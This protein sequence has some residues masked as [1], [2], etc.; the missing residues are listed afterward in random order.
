MNIYE[1]KINSF[2]KKADIKLNGDRP[3]DIQLKDK[4][5]FHKTIWEGTLGFGESYV[6]GYFDCQQLD[7]L[8]YKLS[9]QIE[10]FKYPKYNKHFIMNFLKKMF[11]NFQSIKNARQVVRHHYNIKPE[12]FKNFLD[13]KMLYT[14]G[15]WKKAENLNQSQEH[16]LDLIAK[17]LQ[18]KKGMQVLDVGCGWGG[19]A[20]YF[21]TKYNVQMTAITNS[22]IQYKYAINNNHH[23]NIKFIYQDY[24]QHQGIYDAIYAAGILEHVGS[25][26]Y[27]TFFQKIKNCLKPTA[28]FLLHTIGFPYKDNFSS[29]WITKYIFPNGELPSPTHITKNI[30]HLFLLDDWHNFG[31]DYDKTLM[32][33]Y[34]N[35]IK[36]FENFRDDYYNDKFFRAW[37]FYFLSCAGSFRSRY[38]H[39]WQILL[40]PIHTTKAPVDI[41]RIS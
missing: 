17:K 31:C 22:Q 24:R 1:K 37:S 13:D 3:W 33:W 15:Y 12:I 23:P 8:C 4:K 6:N 34:K 25:K 26:N 35:F 16:K 39:L 7:V 38:L 9:M 28:S 41:P 29:S 30:E 5:F 27:K 10:H 14:C 20:Y 18:F 11:V 21:A 19:S 40:T 2:L 36:T 32:Q